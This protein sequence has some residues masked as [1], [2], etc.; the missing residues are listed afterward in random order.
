[1]MK[2]AHDS[3]ITL[4][5]VIP[6]Y[7]EAAT[8]EACLDRVLAI[9]DDTLRIEAIVVDDASSDG[10]AELAERYAHTNPGVTVLRHRDNQGKGAA[11]RSGIRNATGDVVAIQ[12]ADLEYN[13]RDLKR[14]MTPILFDEA[15]VVLGTRFAATGA[16]RVLYFWHYLGNRFLTLLSN[17]LTD[18]NISDMECCYKVFRRDII[19][20]I[21][22]QE[23]RFGV[24]PELV[25][26]VAQKRVRIFEMGVSYS[27]RTYD[28]GKKIGARDGIR[29]LY[30][31]LRYSGFKAPLP[32]QFLA[33]TGI[34]LIAALVNIFFFLLLRGSGVSDNYALAVAYLP[35][36]CTDYLLA[37][38]LLFRHKARWSAEMEA[39][40]FIL[41]TAA[42]CMI[43]FAVTRALL[44]ASTGPFGSKFAGCFSVLAFNF[45]GRRFLVFP[46]ASAGPWKSILTR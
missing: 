23:N 22:I 9:Q 42:S 29:A 5:V 40:W 28:E 45:I 34:A 1:M 30:C 18:L 11:L 43:D 37:T 24:E 4:S 16:H 3:P 17:M 15:D 2:C 10:S 32:L 12:D 35:A 14:L 13:P 25:A 8:L 7:N 27:G 38:R 26:K 46:E 41:V 33:Y 36:A 20:S 19:Q 39:F 31:I 44:D 21:E 6:C